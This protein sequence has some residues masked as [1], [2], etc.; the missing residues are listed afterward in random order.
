[1][2]VLTCIARLEAKPGFEA[3]VRA[4]L[5]KL[6]EPSRREEGCLNYDMH[7][8][9]DAPQVFMFHENWTSE[10]MLDQHLQSEHIQ[11]C[12][13]EIGE[14]LASVDVQRLTRIES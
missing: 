6:L 2:T 4:E 10:A 13:A 8:V 5:S 7:V 9:N 3:K 1:M 11:A 14:L 12:F